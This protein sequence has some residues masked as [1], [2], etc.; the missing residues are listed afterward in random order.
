M[1]HISYLP[2]DQL[3]NVSPLATRD[4]LRFPL[5]ASVSSWHV[6]P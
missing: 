1:R 6:R 3:N 2:E 5:F 4:V